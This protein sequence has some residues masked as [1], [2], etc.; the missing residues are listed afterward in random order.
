M[1]V[2]VMTN[3]IKNY[4]LTKINQE[5]NIRDN[6]LKAELAKLPIAD[7]MYDCLVDNETAQMLY[8]LGSQGLL[9]TDMTATFM[10]V[11]LRNRNGFSVHFSAAF[12]AHRYMPAKLFRTQKITPSTGIPSNTKIQ[13]ILDKCEELQKEWNSTMESCRN[14]LNSCRTLKQV[15]TYW[16]GVLNYLPDYAIQ[17]HS[18]QPE[19]RQRFKPDIEELS[20]EVKVSLIKNRMI[21][22]TRNESN[23]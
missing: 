14:I 20:T 23:T 8:K 19:R 17:L 2:V 22:A 4:I 15:L 21:G 13:E 3:S 1:A 18:K 5:F 6:L 16:D 7:E 12:A 9:H 10:E 11:V